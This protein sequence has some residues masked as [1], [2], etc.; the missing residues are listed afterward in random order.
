MKKT[1]ISISIICLLNLSC[2]LKKIRLLLIRRK[3]QEQQ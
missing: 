2:T 1:I 3:I